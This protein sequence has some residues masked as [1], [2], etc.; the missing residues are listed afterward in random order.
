MRVF[1]KRF[2]GFDPERHPV[3]AFG[4]AGNRDALITAS[5][6]GDLVVFIGTQDEPTAEHERGRLLGIAEFARIPV[7]VRDVTD[8]TK[9][10][11]TDFAADGSLLWPKGLPVLRAWRFAEPRLKLI[12]VLREQLTFEATVRAVQLDESDTRAVLALPKTEVAIT[13]VPHV[14][15]LLA[16]SDALA[17]GRPTTG[18]TPSDWAGT[19]TR[20]TEAEAWTY[21]MRFG[22]RSVWKVGHTQ[23][24]DQRLNDVNKHIPIEEIGE[25]WTLALK[26]RW[27]NS[28]AA[29][30]MEQRVFQNLSASRTTGERIRCSEGQ[31]LSAWS[32]S[33]AG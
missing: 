21:A 29:Y 14:A 5:S 24:V 17:F 9:M 4:K 31:M 28:V 33:L 25:G 10:K 18:P 6:P 16:L 12:D 30:A 27:P 8:P 3:I 7:D 15:K 32:S 2:Y 13:L 26:Q 22:K 11:P 19:V 23:N 1:A 20:T